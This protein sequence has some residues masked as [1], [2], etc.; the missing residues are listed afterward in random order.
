M[1]DILSFAGLSPKE[2]Q[3]LQWSMSGLAD[4][5][6]AARLGLS[7][8]TVKT[9]WK[10]IRLKVGGQTRAEIIALLLERGASVALEASR[11]ER[12]QLRKE[13]DA[14]RQLEDDRRAIA[15]ASFDMIVVF[16]AVLDTKGAVTRHACL[17]CNAG[18]AAFAK[19]SPE[20]AIG[21]DLGDLLPADLARDLCALMR[22]AGQAAKDPATRRASSWTIS[23]ED[24]LDVRIVATAKGP[25]VGLR[26]V[27]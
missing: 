7:L 24:G 26:K 17:F 3:V 9:Y 4:K 5:E 6:V 15:E 10:R 11:S 21:A 22:E 23:F 1:N 13:L 8:D 20:E 2:Q 27:S 18:F 14:Y 25:V 12:D 19:R 16:E